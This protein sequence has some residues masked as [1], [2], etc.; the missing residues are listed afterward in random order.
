MDQ[1][2]QYLF[3]RIYNSLGKESTATTRGIIG[4]QIDMTADPDD[5]TKWAFRDPKVVDTIDKF[6]VYLKRL[7]QDAGVRHTK[8]GDL[9]VRSSSVLYRELVEFRDN[10]LITGVKNI[11]ETDHAKMERKRERIKSL[12]KK[13]KGAKKALLKAQTEVSK[14][15]DLYH[16]QE[17]TIDELKG[18][19]TALELEKE[20][21]RKDA[22][23]H[24]RTLTGLIQDLK[25]QNDGLFSALSD[26]EEKLRLE[27]SKNE[28]LVSKDYKLGEFEGFIRDILN[29][30]TIHNGSDSLNQV[31]LNYSTYY[32]PRGVY[33]ALKD[34]LSQ[35]NEISISYHVDTDAAQAAIME[36][37]V[38]YAKDNLGFSID[39]SEILDDST[40]SAPKMSLFKAVLCF[41]RNTI[42]NTFNMRSDETTVFYKEV[43]AR[44]GIDTD[45][46]V[47]RPEDIQR[48]DYRESEY[49]QAG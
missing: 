11:L 23:D 43:L 44:R 38:Q 5:P 19:I 2:Y 9:D 24:A 3:Q 28:E 7:T 29:R 27:S 35:N 33:D 13:I 34:H 49:M 32:I 39:R 4:H 26:I 16:R 36:S 46:E 15:E 45:V 37:I 48:G 21:A 17:T 22:C 1:L 18:K 12:A 40:S 8:K 14:A 30:S 47:I 41:I 25:K 20:N 10:D 31:M 6:M 42:I